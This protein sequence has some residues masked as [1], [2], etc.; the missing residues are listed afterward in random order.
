MKTMKIAILTSIL[1]MSSLVFAEGGG[2]RT[3]ARMEKALEVALSANQPP[4]SAEAKED[5]AQQKPAADEKK[6]HC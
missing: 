3:F 5:V 4:A 1:V 6:P 2:D